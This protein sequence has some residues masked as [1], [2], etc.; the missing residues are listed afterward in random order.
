VRSHGRRVIPGPRSIGSLCLRPCRG[1][2]RE[3]FPVAEPRIARP[4]DDG[5][6]D[7]R[8]IVRIDSRGRLR[9][10][11]IALEPINADFLGSN[12]NE[13]AGTAE[14]ISEEDLDLLGGCAGGGQ[15]SD[16]PGR[17]AFARNRSRSGTRGVRA[18]DDI[19]RIPSAIAFIGD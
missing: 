14:R 11:I 10:V 16:E 8:W 7:F 12:T 3:W 6:A 19:K 17:L 15:V 13:G 4:F 2:E 5:G 18:G 1:I 9:S